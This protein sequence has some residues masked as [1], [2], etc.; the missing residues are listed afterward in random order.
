MGSGSSVG[1]PALTSN[2]PT[3]SPPG[4]A[5]DS[6]SYAVDQQHPVHR[7]DSRPS[8]ASQL[9]ASALISDGFNIPHLEAENQAPPAYGAVHDQMHFSQAGLQAGASIA[10][11]SWALRQ[12]D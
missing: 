7:Q 8:T 3:A 12:H 11:T 4:G 9:A 5:P 2:P 6:A 1:A 10:G